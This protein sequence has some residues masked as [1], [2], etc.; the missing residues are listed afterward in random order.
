MEGESKNLKFTLSF[1]IFI[2]LQQL[3]CYRDVDILCILFPALFELLNPYLLF[4]SF[5]R[6]Y[7][8]IVA[9]V[10]KKPENGLEL[11]TLLNKSSQAEEALF[12]NNDWEN[13]KLIYWKEHR[14]AHRF[15]QWSF[16]HSCFMYYF[17]SFA[18]RK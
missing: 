18:S 11:L 12:F 3:Y 6:V 17:S 16:L 9:T 4:Q 13:E 1:Y 7:K 10:L 14:G 15:L 2:D 8:Q 5:A